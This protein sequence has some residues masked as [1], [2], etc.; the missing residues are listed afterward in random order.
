MSKRAWLSRRFPVCAG[1]ALLGAGAAPNLLAASLDCAPRP[2]RWQEDCSEIAH[3]DAA[4]GW[5]R[6]RGV[7]LGRDRLGWLTLGGEYRFRVE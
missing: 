7:P 3:D 4:L 6:L 5:R 1:V 2:F